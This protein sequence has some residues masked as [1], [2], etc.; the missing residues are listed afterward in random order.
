MCQRFLDHGYDFYA[1]DMRKCGR[2]IIVPAQDQYK[3]YCSDLHEYDEEITLTIEHI[4]QQGNGKDT[5]I[6]LL[7]HSTGRTNETTWAKSVLS[8]ACSQEV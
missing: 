4:R 7:G 8:F 5:K 1:L 6:L 3:H 2:S